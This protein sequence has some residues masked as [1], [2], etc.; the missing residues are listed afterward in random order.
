MKAKNWLPVECMTVFLTLLF[1]IWKDIS[2]EMLVIRYFVWFLFLNFV[3]KWLFS[4]LSLIRF[5]NCA[6]YW[7]AGDESPQY[8]YARPLKSAWLLLQ[9]R[10][11][12]FL[13]VFNVVAFL[14]WTLK[15]T[16][17]SCENKDTP[18]AKGKCVIEL[19]LHLYFG[20]SLAIPSHNDLDSEPKFRSMMLIN[21]GYIN[22]ISL[23]SCMTGESFQTFLACI[24]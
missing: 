18:C 1:K 17:S 3:F 9:F 4:F 22:C 21:Q 23:L 10:S 12:E 7:Q 14:C 13:E 11:Q 5:A 2:Q 15:Y 8:S 24:P 20:C 16:S 6:E 19:E